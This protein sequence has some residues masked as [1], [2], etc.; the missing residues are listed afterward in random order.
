MDE[1]EIAQYEKL[2]L[3]PVDKLITMLAIPTVISMLTTM[4]Y[5]L[6]DAYFVGKLG[7]S[8]AAAIGILVSVSAVFQAVGFMFGQGSGSGIAVT[9]GEGKR[10]EASKIG[11]TG[12]FASLLFAVVIT[13]GEFACFRPLLSFLGST[14]TI[15]PYAYTYGIYILAAGPA[16]AGSCV[17]N[18]IMRY[19]G[20]AFWAMIGLVSGGVINMALDPFFMFELNMG[21][22]GAG[23]ATALSQYIAFFILLYMFLS[24]K[25]ITRISP[26]FIT[27]EFRD[28]RWIIARG[29]PSLIRQLLHSGAS[30]TLNIC[31]KPY[32]DAAIAAMAIVGRVIMF[33]GSTM[34]GIGQGFQP[35]SGYNYGAKKYR[36]LRR[37]FFFTWRAGQVLLT[38][39]AIIGFL[40]PEP[41]VRLFRDDP[42]VIAI[43][44]PALRFQCIALVMQPF[45]ICSNM[46]FQSIGH[47]KVATFLSMLRGGLC[48]I[49]VLLI[50]PHFLGITGIECAQLVA[51]VLTI[52]I[53]IP[54]T[55][56]FFRKTPME[57][58][59]SEI[60]EKYERTVGNHEQEVLS[61]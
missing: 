6:V 5:N 3:R 58:E 29:F 30:A 15:L 34:I 57:D 27:R 1:K 32:G 44:V 59:R 35:V 42:E 12:F 56:A 54:F 36:R 19:E 51:D 41:V 49:P 7:T 55:V 21:I 9:L 26:R 18:N 25:T 17:L 20:K 31:A 61:V 24:G 28:L 38:T 8:A 39:L 2:V 60:D 48:Y 33:I 45:N 37:G 43:G 4:I 23:L 46:L 11:S 53:T 22:A 40:I 14:E 16:M 50:L 13:L 47:A 52:I 10:E